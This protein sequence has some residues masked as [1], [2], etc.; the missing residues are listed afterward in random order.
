MPIDPELQRVRQLNDEARMYLTDGKVLM[1]RGIAGLP[2]EDQAAILD[3]VR[4]FDDFAPANDP[5]GEH[6]FGAF[7]HND[8]R[9][10]WKIDYYDREERLGSPDP[11]DPHMTKRVLTVMLAGEY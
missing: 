7:E 10:F 3:R 1:T 2:E 9:I 4:A 8:K 11:A 5:Y 6:D